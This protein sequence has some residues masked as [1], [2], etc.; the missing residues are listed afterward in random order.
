VLSSPTGGA[1]ITTGTGTVTVLENEGAPSFSINSVSLNEASGTT[2][3]TVTK[4]GATSLAHSVNYASSGGTATAGVDYTAIALNTLT[5]QPADTTKTITVNAS[6]DSVFENGESYNV[7]LSSPTAGA[8]ISSGTGTVSIVDS[9]GVSFSVTPLSQFEGSGSM[10]F[11][12]TKTGGTVFSHSVS[13]STANGSATAGSDYTAA[14]GALTF[15]SGQTSQTFSVPIAFDGSVTYE[16]N[17]TFFVNLSGATGGATIATPSVTNTIVDPNV[18]QFE[19]A[20]T[21]F[22]EAQGTVTVTVTKTGNTA[23]THTMNYQNGGGT[24][25]AGSDYTAFSGTVTFAPAETS[26]T[27][28]MSITDDAVLE[29]NETVLVSLS[30]FVNGGFSNNSGVLTLLDNESANSILIDNILMQ[31]T[32]FGENTFAYYQLSSSGDVITNGNCVGGDCI[33]GDRGDWITPKTNISNY[34][35]RATK[36]GSPQCVNTGAVSLAFGTWLNLSTSPQWGVSL[37]APEPSTTSENCQLLIE[38][39]ASANPTVILESA[40]VSFNLWTGL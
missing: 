2:M 4:S 28:T 6:N 8:T 25:T 3:L 34:Q 15:T 26:R 16:G 17:E 10:T 22:T 1:T 20:S 35:A 38:I 13:Y 19:V 18:P 11:T 12:V 36:I 40:T 29:S 32:S 14:S 24:A 21:S 5:F 23:L 9:T 31:G 30:N 27:F 33:S 39:R 37:S 7:V